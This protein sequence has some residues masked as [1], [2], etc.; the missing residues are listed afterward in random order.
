MTLGKT[1]KE[2]EDII[3]KGFLNEKWLV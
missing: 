1:K 2:A 3:V